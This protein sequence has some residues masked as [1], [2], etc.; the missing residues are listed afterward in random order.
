VAAGG[1]VALALVASV[2]LAIDRH[3]PEWDHAN[4]LEAAVECARGV[5]TGDWDAVLGHSPFYPPLALCA[6]GLGYLIAP[7]DL[8]AAGAVMIAALGLGMMATYL[9]ARPVTGDVGAAVAAL[10]YGTAPYVVFSTLR[11]QLDL[12]LAAMVAVALVVI[13]AADGLRHPGWA[14][15]TGIVLGLG[16][17]TKPTFALYVAPA[18]LWLLRGMRHPRGMA[19]G[20]LVLGVAIAVALPWY[21]PRLFG[22]PSQVAWRAVSSEETGHL[23]PR[24][25]AAWLRYPAWFPWQFGVAA[26]ALFVVGLVV[27]IRWRR[28]WLLAS[29][30]GP[31]L[32][33]EALRNKNLRYTLPLLPLAA[34]VAAI[35][36]GALPRAVRVGAAV[37]LAVLAVLQVGA[38]AFDRPRDARVPILEIPLGVVSPPARDD[39]RQREILALIAADSGRRAATVSV[40]PNHPL[41]SV[42]NFRYYALREELPFEF[43]RAWD[44]TPL[45]IEYAILKTGDVG[46]PWTERRIRQVTASLDEPNGVGRLFP[47][48]GRFSLPD[49][50]EATV[51]VRRLKHV[52]GASS[53]DVGAAAERAFGRWIAN[54]A[55]D[56]EGGSLRLRHGE[57]AREGRIAEVALSAE[58]ATFSEFQRPR[59]ARLRMENV[60]VVVE[61]VVIN[62]FSAVDQGRLELLDLGRLRL[63]R[64]TITAEDLARF[65]GELPKFKVQ[66]ALEPGALAVAVRQFGPDVTGRVRVLPVPAV[67]L[68]VRLIPEDVRIG[69]VALPDTVV[70]W[71]M[72]QYDP[73]GRIARRL[74]MPVSVGRIAV[75]PSAVTI[76]PEP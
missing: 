45:G 71:V 2:W 4:H 60:R 28:W 6:A 53:A 33:V 36:W 18:L 61:D 29:L 7:T 32:V 49:G 12:P 40:V 9:L 68:P 76:G 43:S 13:R 14:L 51:R 72:R 64:A 23:D 66:V 63:E 65:L 26:A 31:L 1:F 50:S 21:G 37:V 73:T 3:P 74:A 57:G 54:Y 16:M 47:V 52:P 44:G 20:L 30:L 59:A 17:L 24:T 39:W 10:L 25:L 46:P 15:L 70:G 56:V 8:A 62:P 55:R 58:R 35:G 75:Q 67:P 19:N 48:I 11:L 69:T 42:S 22:L 34:V 41:F 27:A 5:R 38:T